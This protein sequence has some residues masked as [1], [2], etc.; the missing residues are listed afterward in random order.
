MIFT[1]NEQYAIAYVV[2]TMLHYGSGSVV[3]RATAHSLLFKVGYNPVSERHPDMIFQD[4]IDTVKPMP[5]EKKKAVLAILANIMV[6]DGNIKKEK[7]QWLNT[8]SAY[9]SCPDISWDETWK[10]IDS[11]D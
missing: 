9:C 4:V 10:I 5:L 11:L 3:E 7:Q 1:K 8:V 2:E 6:A